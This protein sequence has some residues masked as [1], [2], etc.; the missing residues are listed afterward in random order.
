[1][2]NDWPKEY[3]VCKKPYE[4]DSVGKWFSEL[5]QTNPFDETHKEVL[6]NRLEN[7]KMSRPTG[8]SIVSM[9]QLSP[10]DNKILMKVRETMPSLPTKSVY[11]DVLQKKGNKAAKGK[12]E[13]KA[14][15]KKDDNEKPAIENKSKI[16]VRAELLI[17]SK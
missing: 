14:E 5:R 4:I 9:I 16:S 8:N 12:K 7:F 6:K 15:M 2:V 1:M 11:K 10:Y 17:A 3:V 13:K